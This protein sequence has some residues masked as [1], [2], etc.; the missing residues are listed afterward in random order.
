MLAAC[1]ARH[2]GLILCLA[3]CAAE[4]PDPCVCLQPVIQRVVRVPQQVLNTVVE[5]RI[6]PVITQQ[7]QPQLQTVVEEGKV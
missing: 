4:P 5:R 6:Q 1:A 7:V 3:S 2:S